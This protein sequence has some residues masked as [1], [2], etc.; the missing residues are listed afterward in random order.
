[1]TR[2][3]LYDVFEASKRDTEKSQR[4]DFRPDWGRE[5][6]KEDAM[7]RLEREEYGRKW[8]YLVELG[9]NVRAIRPI[10]NDAKAKSWLGQR[11][12]KDKIERARRGAIRVATLF[13]VHF[14]R[15]YANNDQQQALLS[16]VW[17]KTTI[18]SQILQGHVRRLPPPLKQPKL[19]AKRRQKRTADEAFKGEE[20]ESNLIDPRLREWSVAPGSQMD[21]QQASQPS[22]S[23]N[24]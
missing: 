18:L 5:M 4:A 12:Y 15:E 10:R 13:T 19:P 3:N 17:P 6:K 1:M 16:R 14:A 23:G 9:K 7:T 8:R 22:R 24:T 20:D 21:W 11:L 2:R